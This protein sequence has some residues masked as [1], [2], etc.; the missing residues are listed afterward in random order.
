MSK[1]RSR[2]KLEQPT[3]SKIQKDRSSQKK[4][5]LA[6]LKSK[7]RPKQKLEQYTRSEIQKDQSSQIKRKKNNPLS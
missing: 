2:Q 7:G 3:R 5:M 6:R 1:G 4:I